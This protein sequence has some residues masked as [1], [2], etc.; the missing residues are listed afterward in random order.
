MI[1]NII[2]IFNTKSASPF[3]PFCPNFLFQKLSNYFMEQKVQ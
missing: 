3:K 2:I 1:I